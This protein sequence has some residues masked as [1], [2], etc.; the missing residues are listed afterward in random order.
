MVAVEVQ[1][2]L[3]LHRAVTPREFLV[4]P[5]DF[6]RIGRV[7]EDLLFPNSVFVA[8][9]TGGVLVKAGLD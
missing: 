5:V 2:H 7:G 8:A 9:E 6:G 3:R 1:E 4:P